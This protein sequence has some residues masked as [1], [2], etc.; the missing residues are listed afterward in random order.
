MSSKIKL[1]YLCLCLISLTACTPVTKEASQTT[2]STTSSQITTPSAPSLTYQDYT[3]VLTPISHDELSQKMAAGEDFLLFLGRE[4][5]AYCQAFVPK[6]Y[7][8]LKDHPKTVYYYNTEDKTDQEL[9]SFRTNYNIAT[10]PHLAYFQGD[11]EV[12]KLDNPRQVTK[13][14]LVNLLNLLQD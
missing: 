14:E 3:A 11:Q 13:E 7:I 5:C 1:S 12:A 2:P 4:T 10:V 8:T 6:L 9:Q